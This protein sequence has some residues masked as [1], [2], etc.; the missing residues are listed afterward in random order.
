MRGLGEKRQKREA[1]RAS[2]LRK[3]HSSENVYFLPEK[4]PLSRLRPLR[5]VERS[6]DGAELL[7]RHMVRGHG[8]RAVA[9]WSDQR[10]RWI[11]PYWKGPEMAAIVEREYR[12]KL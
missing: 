1:T 2:E 3:A 12:M 7:A 11:E 10:M 6:H 4:I 9:T 5:D 8:R